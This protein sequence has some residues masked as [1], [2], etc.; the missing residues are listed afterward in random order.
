MTPRICQ[1]WPRQSR[2]CLNCSQWYRKDLEYRNLFPRCW[3]LRWTVVW[4]KRTYQCRWSWIPCSSLCR[5]WWTSIS[6]CRC[7]HQRKGCYWD[8]GR[9]Q[10]AVWDQLWW[11]VQKLTEHTSPLDVMYVNHRTRIP[12]LN[13]Y[14]P[15]PGMLPPILND[16]GD[17]VN[18]EPR[19]VEMSICPLFGSHG[20]VKDIC[21]GVLLQQRAA[22][23]EQLYRIEIRVLEVH[24]PSKCRFINVMSPRQTIVE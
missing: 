18:V 13:T 4:E 8:S 21:R 5:N 6:H 20:F 14:I 12:R 7:E 9:P 23:V 1:R 3:W 19:S 10:D 24:K 2:F 16:N 15:R 22:V 17:G 11:R